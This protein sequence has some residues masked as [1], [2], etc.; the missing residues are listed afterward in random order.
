MQGLAICSLDLNII[1]HIWGLIKSQFMKKI[2]KR[3]ELI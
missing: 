1:E 2:N 3:S